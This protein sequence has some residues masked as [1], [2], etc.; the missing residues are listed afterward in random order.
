MNAYE[1]AERIISAPVDTNFDM[2]E[3]E[4]K[5]LRDKEV[6]EDAAAEMEEIEAAAKKIAQILAGNKKKRGR[7]PKIFLDKTS[8]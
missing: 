8:K 6:D 3:V 5:G 1:I 7:K 2:A 4:T